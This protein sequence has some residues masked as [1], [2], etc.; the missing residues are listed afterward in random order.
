MS[1]RG[2]VERIQV[3]VTEKPSGMILSKLAIPL[4]FY[5][6]SLWLSLSISI[7]YFNLG[8]NNFQ[9]NKSWQIHVQDRAQIPGSTSFSAIESTAISHKAQ[10]TE[11]PSAWRN[12]PD[13]GSGADIFGWLRRKEEPRVEFMLQVWKSKMQRQLRNESKY[14]FLNFWE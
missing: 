8:F 1:K 4:S 5:Y 6:V 10:C 3:S 13:I 2:G 11:K 7:C 14:T 12:D 9:P